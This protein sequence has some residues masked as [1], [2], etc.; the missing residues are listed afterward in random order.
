MVADAGLEPASPNGREILSLLCIPFHQSAIIIIYHAQHS[1]STALGPYT[2]RE[3]SNKLDFIFQE[4]AKFAIQ[5]INLV[6]RFH[7][8]PVILP[9]NIDYYAVIWKILI[10]FIVEIRIKVI[11]VISTFYKI[12]NLIF[13]GTQVHTLNRCALC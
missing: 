13:R 6:H 1:S 4:K 11:K 5:T 7:I 10:V 3:M 2:V 12:A 8:I 9:C